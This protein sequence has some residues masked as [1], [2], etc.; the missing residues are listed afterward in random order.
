MSASSRS[1]EEKLQILPP[2]L[3]ADAI[4]YIDELVKRSKKRSSKTFRCAAEGTLADLGTKHLS[5]DLQ[6]KALEWR[7]A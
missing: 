4:H 5:V 1:V 3:R 6:H 7:E 2:D